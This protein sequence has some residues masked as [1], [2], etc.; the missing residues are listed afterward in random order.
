V[1]SSK[2]KLLIVAAIFML[3]AA[4]ALSGLASANLKA[5]PL[6]QAPAAPAQKQTLRLATTTSMQDSGL[7]DN[8]LPG[9]EKA[10]NVKVDVIAVGSGA[11]MQ[12]GASG[13]AD[14]LIVHSPAAEKAFMDAG[15]G[16]ERAQ[17]AYNYFVIVGPK[18]D[19]A[20]IRGMDNAAKAFKKIFDT[21]STFV[22]RGDNSGTAVKEAN[23]WK[24][25]GLPMPDRQMAWYKSTGAGMAE[26][27]RI[28]DQLNGYTLSDKSTFLD[29]QKNLQTLEI[30]VGASPDMLNTYDVIV[31]SKEKHPGVNSALAQ[32]FLDYLTSPETQAKIGQY[33]MNTVGQPLFMAATS[34]PAMAPQPAAAAA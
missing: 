34:P 30:L 15:Q 18:N 9:F 11:A 19:P 13:D 3:V 16:S 25:T 21:K 27:L 33:G 22:G 4:T 32:K 23:L 31:V 29:L 2:V 10:N 1:Q 8:I 6:A 26:T 20:G 28:A 24:A 5:K 17:F 12:M 7:L 14:V